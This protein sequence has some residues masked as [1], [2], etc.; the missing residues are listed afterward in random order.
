[1]RKRFAAA[2]AHPLDGLNEG[3]QVQC[4]SLKGAAYVDTVNNSPDTAD[5]DP[6]NL[7]R[8]PSVLERVGIGRT[9]WLDMVP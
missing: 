4:H 5:T 1:L 6:G 9:A 2:K 7:L 3:R 8:L